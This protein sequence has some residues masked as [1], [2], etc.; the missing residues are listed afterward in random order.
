[1][2]YFIQLVF[3]GIALGCIYALIGLGFTIIFKASEVINFAQGS[4]LLVGAY[5][6]SAGV[7]EWHLPFFLALVLGILVTSCIGLLLVWIL[8][9]APSLLLSGDRTPFL[10]PR[11]LNSP[12]VLLLAA[13][14][15]A[16]TNYGPSLSRCYCAPLYITFS[17]SRNMGW[18]CEPRQLTRKL[19]W[20]WASTFALC[21]RWTGGCLPLL[22][23]LT[24]AFWRSMPLL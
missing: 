20:L 18:R 12:V 3:A 14:T 10:P 9:F 4:L 2:A 6:V 5:I 22:H 23:R 21:M 11:H 8:C 13:F 24:L 16:Q 17:V 19:R 1:M 7:F 15:L